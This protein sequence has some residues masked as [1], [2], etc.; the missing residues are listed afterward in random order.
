MKIYNVGGSVRDKLM[1][2]EPKDLDYVVVLDDINLSVEEGFKKME[3]FLIKEGYTIWLSTPEMVTIRAKFPVGHKFKGDADFVLARKELGYQSD[4][5]RPRVVLGLLIDDLARRDFT[6]N[7]MA[8][9]EDGNI[10]DPFNGRKDLKRM[11]LETPLPS[12]ITLRDDPLRLL[13]AFRFH[14]TKG[15]EMS[16]ELKLAMRDPSVM[17]KLETVVSQERIREELEKMF[18]FDTIKT[19]SLIAGSNALAFPRLLEICFG[20][21][22]WLKP[23]TKTK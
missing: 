22:M 11:V 18:K 3:D 6:V 4:S 16:R 12:L 15:F 23:T 8:E 13:R 5:R 9:D 2:L 1:G 20:K 21:D 19:F 14:V 17:N 7:A 10:I